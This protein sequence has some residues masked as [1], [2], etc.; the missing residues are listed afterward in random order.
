MLNNNYQNTMKK[1]ESNAKTRYEIAEEYGVCTKT[2]NKWL[3]TNNINIGHGLITPKEQKMIY[4]K[5]GFP[6]NS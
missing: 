4:L 6:K 3:R 1:M 2:L 5:L